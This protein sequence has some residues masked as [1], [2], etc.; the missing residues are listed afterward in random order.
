[1]S[2][3]SNTKRTYSIRDT[4]AERWSRLY[5]DVRAGYGRAAIQAALFLNGSAPL[6]TFLGNL[7][8]A[9][10][11]EPSR[12]SRAA[13]STRRPSRAPWARSIGQELAASSMGR[14]R[15]RSKSRSARTRRIPTLDLP[16]GLEFAAGAADR[17]EIWALVPIDYFALRRDYG[18]PHVKEL[19]LSKK[20][21]A[22]THICC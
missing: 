15:S 10:E 22:I 19:R 21:E 20:F 16:C 13:H 2:N 4:P 6:P 18:R 7:A 17:C 11:P 3:P 5:V 1:M 9:P 8:I 12:S 14:A